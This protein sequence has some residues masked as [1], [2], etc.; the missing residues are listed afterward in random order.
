MKGIILAGGTG[1]RLY[2]LTR[3][4]SKQLMAVY[5]KPMIY[6]PLTTLMMAGICDILVITTPEDQP[7]FRRA[8]GDGQQWGIRLD[9][10]VQTA[11]EGIAQAFLIAESFL[12][13]QGCALCLG[14][15]LFFGHGLAALLQASREQTARQAGGATIFAHEV[16]DPQRYGVVTFD[17]NGTPVSIIEKPRAPGSRWAVTGLYFYDHTVVDI[18]R[19]LTP[20]A[21]GELEIS[22]VNAAYLARGDLSVTRLGRGFCWFDTGTHDSLHD[23]ANF[24]QAVQKRQGLQIASPEEVAYRMGWL[25]AD[26]VAALAW[27]MRANAYGAYLFHLIGRDVCE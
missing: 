27:P 17:A 22:D 12:D 21:R 26:Q 4:V 20:S 25:S 6:F 14:D 18:A 3:G 16:S 8:L 9:Y 5:D 24:V 2:P 1:S 23:A 15:N 19:G 13:G 7:M 11:P 10:A